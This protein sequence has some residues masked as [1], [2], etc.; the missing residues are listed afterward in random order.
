MVLPDWLERLSVFGG[1]GILMP[2]ALICVSVAFFGFVIFNLN[3][4]VSVLNASASTLSELGRAKVAEKGWDG[5]TP[6]CCFP[7]PQRR[8][9]RTSTNGLITLENKQAT[10]R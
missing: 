6:S 9:D 7:K 5:S 3:R 2:K 10:R 1:A 4:S 8:D